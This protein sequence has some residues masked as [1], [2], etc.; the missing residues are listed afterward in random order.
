MSLKHMNRADKKK[1]FKIVN[2]AWHK[3]HVVFDDVREIP[4]IQQIWALL[5]K[6][7]VKITCKLRNYLKIGV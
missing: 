7:S 4:K 3:Y 1:A 2:N 6:I 5:T